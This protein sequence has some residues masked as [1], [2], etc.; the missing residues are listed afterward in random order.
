VK[1]LHK[2]TNHELTDVQLGILN[3]YTFYGKN[4]VIFYSDGRV[5]ISDGRVGIDETTSWAKWNNGDWLP[6]IKDL[7]KRPLS[8]LNIIVEMRQ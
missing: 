7:N 3:Y 8:E 2:I 5:G 4:K 1:N 6:Y